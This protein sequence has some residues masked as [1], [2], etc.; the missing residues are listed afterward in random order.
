[1]KGL[2]TTFRC[3]SVWVGTLIQTRRLDIFFR[4]WPFGR[5][6]CTDAAGKGVGSFIQVIRAYKRVGG[7]TDLSGFWNIRIFNKVFYLISSMRSARFRQRK[8][9]RKG[10]RS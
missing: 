3:E 7:F 10:N 8:R 5:D 4:V 9:R 6:K 1:M 2:D